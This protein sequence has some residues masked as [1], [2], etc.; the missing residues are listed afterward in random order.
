MT[1]HRFD[2][3]PD[4]HPRARVR[5]ATGLA[6]AHI[7]VLLMAVLVSFLAGPVARAGDAQVHHLRLISWSEPIDDLKFLNGDGTVVPVE[8]PLNRFSPVYQY[9]GPGPVIM[10]TAGPGGKAGFKQ[11]AMVPLA[12]TA[13]D[14]VLWVLFTG[15]DA[16]GQYVT[17][18]IEEKESDFPPGGYRFLNFSEYPLHIKCG[19]WEM[20]APPWK[21]A[22]FHP[23]TTDSAQIMPVEIRAERDGEMKRVYSNRW[24]YGKAT[25]TLVLAYFDAGTQAYELKRI[26]A[27]TD[28]AAANPEPGLKG[29]PAKNR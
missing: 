26:T 28:P 3:Q 11:M 27:E 18:G 15:T 17:S 8:I 16:V 22:S 19:D 23:N 1:T 20:I 7:L 21:S 10:G 6:P 4:C 13:S 5:R 9:K 12:E 24:P 29:K 2:P 14:G 25:R